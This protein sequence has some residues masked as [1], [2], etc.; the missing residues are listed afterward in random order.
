MK[1]D[2]YQ[3]REDKNFL[4]SYRDNKML[5]CWM[6]KT[7]YVPLKLLHKLRSSDFLEFTASYLEDKFVW[8]SHFS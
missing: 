1:E 5:L 7:L 6:L 3:H 2:S 8:T 4:E